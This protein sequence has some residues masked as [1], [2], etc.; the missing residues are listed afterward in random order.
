MDQLDDW[1]QRVSGTII[2]GAPK[3]DTADKTLALIKQKMDSASDG[4]QSIFTQVLSELATNIHSIYQPTEAGLDKCLIAL[5]KALASRKES[6]D[7]A[8]ESHDVDVLL[9]YGLLIATIEKIK[10]QTV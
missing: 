3:N 4:E 6:D 7:S 1:C 8:A 5:R 2:D 10:E 9:F